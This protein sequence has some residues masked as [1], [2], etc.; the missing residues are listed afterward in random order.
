[1]QTQ[2]TA[3]DLMTIWEKIVSGQILSL[4]L[5]EW[6]LIVGIITLTVIACKI[7][8]KTFKIL[9][10]AAIVILIVLFCISRGWIVL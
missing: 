8:R 5:T 2:E 9:L 6:I 3:Q 10:I 4:T 7:L 1:M